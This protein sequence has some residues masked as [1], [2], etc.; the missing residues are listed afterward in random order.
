MKITDQEV[1]MWDKTLK[2]TPRLVEKNHKGEW[3]PENF[4]TEKIRELAKK[5]KMSG[6]L[7]FEKI[8]S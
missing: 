3:K 1:A 6:H 2:D 5:R 4:S 8:A 7:P